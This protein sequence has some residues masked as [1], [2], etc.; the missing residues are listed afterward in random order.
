MSAESKVEKIR[1]IQNLIYE[2][3]AKVSENT[4][5]A[6]LHRAKVEENHFH[7][8]ANTTANGVALRDL[9]TKGL[10]SHLAIC[11]HELNQVESE[12]EEKRIHVK[13]ATLKL[14][15]EHLK[16][17]IEINRGLI[18]I[19]QS[20]VEINKQ[21]IAVNASS[22]GFTD[23]IV[24]AAA[25]TDLHHDRVMQEVLDE[26]YSIS[27]EMID[28]LNEI[29]DSL[30]ETVAENTAHIEKLNSESDQ[31]RLAIAR[32]NKRIHQLIDM[33]LEVSNYN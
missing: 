9:A 1:R 31:N 18:R 13:F 12:D 29:C 20:L 8:L 27:S 22:A 30:V 26:E 23:E 25:S 21:M 5:K 11:L 4:A 14:L 6:G 24:L 19:N 33:V 16:A 15:I 3:S 10:E 17:R 7:I 32:N 2:L 28:E